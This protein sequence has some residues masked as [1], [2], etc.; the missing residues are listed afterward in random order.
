MAICTYLVT[1][2]KP[3]QTPKTGTLEAIKEYNFNQ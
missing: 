2:E 3:N 1:P